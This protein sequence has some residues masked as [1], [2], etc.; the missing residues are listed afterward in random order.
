MTT[1][2]LT[3]QGV[4]EQRQSAEDLVRSLPGA[5][6]TAKATDLF[7]AQ[8]DENAVQALQ[9]DPNWSVSEQTFAEIRSPALNLKNMRARLDRK[10]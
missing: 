5:V 4:P 6:L 3:Y 10:R 7:E 2:V 1:V 8:L 9:Q